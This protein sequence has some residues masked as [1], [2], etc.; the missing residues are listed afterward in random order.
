MP[1]LV[2]KAI[3][4][5]TNPRFW[6]TLG[7][8]VLLSA[9]GLTY[10]NEQKLADRTLASKVNLP[11]AVM[12]QDFDRAR[13]SNLLGELQVLVEADFAQS[14][15]QDFGEG[16]FRES[17]L[18]LP[19]YPVGLGGTQRALQHLSPDHSQRHRP[20]P[21]IAADET[22]APIAVLVYDVTNR[23]MRP[24]DPD[25]FGLTVLGRGFTGDVALV[26]GVAFSRAILAQGVTQ[27]DVEAAAQESFSLSQAEALPLIAPYV[28]PRAAPAGTDMTHARNVLASVAM[29]ALLFGI[30][31]MTR[32]VK[33]APRPAMRSGPRKPNQVTSR[34]STYFD[35]LMPQ[36]EL[37]D[38]DSKRKVSSEMTFQRISRH[39][40]PVLSRLKSRR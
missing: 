30:S 35:P 11:D 1:R 40:G 29:I 19:V 12:V 27:S 28:A 14:V 25:D 31:L 8:V 34:H 39:A 7:V 13:D 24:R 15:V 36:D 17:F 6:V 3:K 18:L 10:H 38:T 32:R 37:R 2:S 4:W 5:L 21:R 33:A 26:S 16:A 20:V 9:M 22:S 23:R